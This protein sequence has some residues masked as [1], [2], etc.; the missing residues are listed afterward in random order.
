MNSLFGPEWQCP[1]L[2]DGRYLRF[3]IVASDITC[4]MAFRS[5]RYL[6]VRRRQVECF[7][8]QLA[9]VAALQQNVG[10][11]R[12]HVRTLWLGRFMRLHREVNAR[13]AEI[14]NQT[15]F[16]A[17]LNPKPSTYQNVIG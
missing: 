2:E 8:P 13:L 16:L 11:S 5:N 9:D 12:Y 4:P 7:P 6:A 3:R 1:Q 17:L 14:V 10:N 15:D